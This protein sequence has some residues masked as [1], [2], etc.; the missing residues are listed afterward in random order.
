M[1]GRGR[2]RSRPRRNRRFILRGS[3]YYKARP[4]EAR[5]K[6]K[7]DSDRVRLAISLLVVGFIR[8][9]DYK[10]IDDINNSIVLYFG[11]FIIFDSI[12]MDNGCI[13]TLIK[14]L[15]KS[16]K[17]GDLRRLKIET[18]YKLLFRSSVNGRKMFHSY[19]DGY[20]NTVIIIQNEYG[21]IFGA[22]VSKQW[23]RS[24]RYSSNTENIQDLKS[25]IFPLTGYDKKLTNIF[26][27][28]GI[29]NHPRFGPCIGGRIEIPN[30]TKDYCRIKSSISYGYGYNSSLSSD[31]DL[32]RIFG[33][34]TKYK[35]IDYEVFALIQKKR[36]IRK[37]LINGPIPK[38]SVPDM[39]ELPLSSTVPNNPIAPIPT[40]APLPSNNDS[41]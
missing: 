9:Y 19:C 30:A 7:R 36:G 27:T 13:D 11:D 17:I 2:G 21:K 4:Q 34:Q 26:A 28:E 41:K 8:S 23:D 1:N 6:K 31:E 10:F 18:K 22:F 33:T 29:N 38:L 5:D 15:E 40:V 24:T 16:H 14:I 32:I 20:P 39:T 25:F 12:I 35:V 3:G 37:D